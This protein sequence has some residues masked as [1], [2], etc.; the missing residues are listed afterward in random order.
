MNQ[1]LFSIVLINYNYG[2]FIRDALES[3]KGQ[4][5]K[6]FEVIICDAGS[7]DN[8]V[9]II[10]EYVGGLE[11]NKE[12]SFSC[13]ISNNSYVTWWCSEKDNGHSEAINKGVSH[14][15][16]R[17]VCWLNSDDMLFPT[18]LESIAK[19]IQSNPKCEWFVGSTTFVN[20]SLEVIK[21]CCAHRFSPLRARYAFFTA[22]GPSSFFTKDLYNKVGGCDEQL[23]YIMDTDLWYKFY[24]LYGAKFCRTID[25]VWIFR[26]HEES[27]TAGSSV[28]KSELASKN[29]TKYVAETI[30]VAH[31]Y[32]WNNPMRSKI[33]TLL[34][35]SWLDKVIAVFRTY[36]RKGRLV[37]DISRR[38]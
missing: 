34:T 2:N 35:V 3:V 16:G 23:H 12:R 10:K 9:S 21:S 22:C 18:A 4:T 31:R 29:W 33:V 20:R 13:A 36:A 6:D 11:K 27:K 25:D 19:K 24:F 14:A 38:M 17:F 5:F 28:S 7:T 26:M 8:S 32:N 37:R 1:P 30:S 15:K